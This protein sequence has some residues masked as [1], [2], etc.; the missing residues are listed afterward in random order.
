MRAFSFLPWALASPALAITISEINGNHFLSPYQVEG[1]SDIEGLITARSSTGFY[2]LGSPL[3]NSRNPTST[4]L[5][6][7]IDDITGVITQA[8]G[9]YTLLS[10]ATLAVTGS[11]PTN[12]EPTELV[13]DGGCSAVVR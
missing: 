6:D 10:L 7:T 12:A 11:N 4:K 3:D 5:G 1:V 9:L 8:Y 2:L 13:V